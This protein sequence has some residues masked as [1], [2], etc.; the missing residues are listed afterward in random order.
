M[1]KNIKYVFLLILFLLVV[2]VVFLYFN[3]KN[4]N[5]LKDKIVDEVDPDAWKNYAEK[6]V[7]QDRGDGWYYTFLI[8]TVDKNREVT[9]NL[10]GGCN[11]KYETLD[12][13][14]TYGY[15]IG[16]VVIRTPGMPS[17]SISDHSK[18]GVMERDEVRVIDEFFDKNQFN[19]KIDIKDL[20]KLTIYNFSKQEILDLYNQ[21][22]EQE[23]NTT[24]ITKFNL[25]DC[26]MRHDYSKNGYKVNIGV[27]FSKSIGIYTVL[28]DLLYDNGDYLS[29]LV[30]SNKATQEQKEIYANLQK[31]GNY[32][33][34]SQEVNLEEEF[35][36]TGEVYERVYELVKR[37]VGDKYAGLNGNIYDTTEN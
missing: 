33:V 17:L 13:Y 11:L 27:Y 7:I 18:N 3:N 24:W 16:G 28:I 12:G 20:D 9:K 34:E 23:F 1:K 25:S 2:I 29:D 30:A 21:A 19:S 22:V 31:M 36:L 37:F 8:T 15:D 5:S 6:L 32:V 35:G 14:N 4:K 26:T 10:F